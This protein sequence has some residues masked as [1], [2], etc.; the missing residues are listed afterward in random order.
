MAPLFSF[1]KSATEVLLVSF[2]IT[3][4]GIFPYTANLFCTFWPIFINVF[5][6]KTENIELQEDTQTLQFR[7][8]Y[9][10]SWPDIGRD[11]IELHDVVRTH[12]RICLGDAVERITG[13]HRV[14]GVGARSGSG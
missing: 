8:F 14:D 9:L 5:T 6:S 4:I 7:N 3:K 12:S 2:G 1:L 10:H 13:L 11:T